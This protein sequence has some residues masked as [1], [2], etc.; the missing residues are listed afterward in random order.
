M[1]KILLH[2]CCGP[3]TI[4]PLHRLRA[5]QW[6]VYSLFYNPYIQPYQEFERRLTTLQE[7]ADREGFKL[8]VRPDYDLEGFL[9]QTV[10]REQHRCITCYSAR[11]EATARLARK[12]R[13]DAFTTTLLYSK[14]QNHALVRSLAEE[15]SHKFDIPFY[16][17]DFRVGWREGQEAARRSGM[18]RQQYCGCI[19]SE[20]DRFYKEP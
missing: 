17:E 7:L 3:C 11:L 9:R 14:Q 12:S 1:A 18:Y 6:D 16:Y 5:Q 20:R 13:F 15:A 10:F 8:I 19:Y 2:S 4:Y